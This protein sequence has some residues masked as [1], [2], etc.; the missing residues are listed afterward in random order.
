V[1][2]WFVD[3]R[4]LVDNTR[5]TGGNI[6][7]GYRYFDAWTNRLW[8]VGVWYDIDD[9]H[10]ET[11]HQIGASF[12][13][14]GDSFDYRFNA[15]IPLDRTKQNAVAMTGF[16]LEAGIPVRG[17]ESHN[18]R[19]FVG[20]Y[21]F[22]VRND[23]DVHG[24]SGRV[25]GNLLPNLS[26]QLEVTND[27][28]FD[29]NIV[30]GVSLFFG[31]DSVPAGRGGNVPYRAIRGQSPTFGGGYSAFGQPGRRIFDSMQ[32]NHNIVVND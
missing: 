32:R 28:M 22:D 25:E 7:G 20:Y 1:G 8:G 6:G 11:F 30:F 13:T 19:A 24:V 16:D 26:V 9:T 5:N 4:L 17:F 27:R 12:E 18:V 2:M 31:G 15:Y 21:F 23:Y 10:S 3:G 29:T 14:L